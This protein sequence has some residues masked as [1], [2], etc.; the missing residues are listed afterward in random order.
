[1]LPNS[2]FEHSKLGVHGVGIKGHYTGMSQPARKAATAGG[3]PPGPSHNITERTK[4]DG[5]GMWENRR[6]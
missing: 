6:S 3:P 2:K 1:M 4:I 5:Q